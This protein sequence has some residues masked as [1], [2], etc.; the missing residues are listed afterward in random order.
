MRPGVTIRDDTG[1]VECR[2]VS[3][4]VQIRHG[5]ERR[6]AVVDEPRLRVLSG[7][8]SLYGLATD[9]LASGRRL[10]D[11][12]DACTSDDTVSYDDVY[13]GRSPWR[14]MTPI[15]HPDPAH[16]V[17]SGTGLTHLGSAAHRQAMHGK[18]DADLTDSMRMFRAGLEGGRPPA[19][20]IGAAP[21]WFYKGTGTVLRAPGEALE[22]P[23][24]GDDG[25]EEAELAGVYVI[26][27]DGQPRRLGMATANEFSD[28][29][30][31]KT[32]YLH[33]AASKLRTCAIGP[34]LVVDPDFT[35]VRGSVVIERDGVAIWTKA[36]ATGDGAMCH[37]LANLEHHHFKH[38]WHRQPG[39]V[40]VHFYG[41]DALSF[42]D[43][44]VLRDG[45]VMVVQFDGFGRA[46]RNPLRVAARRP[47]P[48]DVTPL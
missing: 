8:E 4:L 19:G 12:I 16:C 45:D 30:L 2:T 26:D 9:A 7:V 31:E 14:L 17:V 46:L 28:H 35:L 23:C 25:G 32:N 22:L 10:H 34:E 29:A 41:A 18:D 21:E 20:A 40:H 27:A 6:V 44:L 15:D 13:T 36:V 48:Q 3:R 42:G 39:D 38:E 24:Y 47:A 11:V 33:L 5:A 1:C 43:G 37:G